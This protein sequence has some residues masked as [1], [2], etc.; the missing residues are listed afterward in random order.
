MK[1]LISF[2]AHNILNENRRVR[3]TANKIVHNIIKSM[4]K[5]KIK[6]GLKDFAFKLKAEGGEYKDVAHVLETYYSTGIITKEQGDLLKRKLA[7]SFKLSFLAGVWLLPGGSIW[8]IAVIKLARKF[9]VQLLPDNL[10]KNKKV[11]DEISK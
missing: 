9:G 1:Y 7:D 6:A 5:E 4:S 2:E 8:S 10:E 11:E 3:N